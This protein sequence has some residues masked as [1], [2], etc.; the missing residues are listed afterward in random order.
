MNTLHF[1]LITK[2][3]QM[4]NVQ[5]HTYQGGSHTY[6]QGVAESPPTCVWRHAH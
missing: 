4:Q 5:T 2:T 6:I 3:Y 1:P